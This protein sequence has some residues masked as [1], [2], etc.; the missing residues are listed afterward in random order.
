VFCGRQKGLVCSLTRLVY[1]GH[2]PDELHRKV[3]ATAQVDAAMIDMT[4]PGISLGE[5]FTTTTETY[6]RCGYPDEWKLHH[7]GGPAGYEPRESIAIPGN[8]FRVAAGQA[9]AWN[10]SITGTKSEDTIL[11]SENGRE[12]ITQIEGWPLIEVEVEGQ[13]YERPAIL[14]VT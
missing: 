9:F 7:Q 12:V 13:M 10:P 8:P 11:V 2:L 3:L 1:F 6:A 5:I 14:E 4:R